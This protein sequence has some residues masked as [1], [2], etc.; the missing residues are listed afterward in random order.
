M[1]SNFVNDAKSSKEN[2]NFQA[3]FNVHVGIIIAKRI[4]INVQETTFG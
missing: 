3:G 4:T 1:I 2:D